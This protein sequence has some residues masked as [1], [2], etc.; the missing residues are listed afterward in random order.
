MRPGNVNF[1]ILAKGERWNVLQQLHATLTQ[2]LQQK[3]SCYFIIK[4]DRAGYTQRTIMTHFQNRAQIC[5]SR[6]RHR[7]SKFFIVHIINHLVALAGADRDISVMN[8]LRAIY[9]FPPIEVFFFC[10]GALAANHLRRVAAVDKGFSQEQFRCSASAEW[11]VPVFCLIYHV[12]LVMLARYWWNADTN[13][14]FAAWG[15]KIIQQ[16]ISSYLTTLCRSRVCSFTLP[17]RIGKRW[18]TGLVRQPV[19]QRGSLMQY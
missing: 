4:N 2:T 16:P 13:L 9:R 5:P 1:K 8:L 11:V 15:V 6:D 18:S 17:G 7:K 3:S 19:A 12:R 14:H 10:Y